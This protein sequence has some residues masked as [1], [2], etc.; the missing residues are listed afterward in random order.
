MALRGVLRFVLGVTV[1]AG[2]WAGDGPVALQTAD[3]SCPDD[4][5]NI[6]VDCGNGTVTDTRSGLTWLKNASC[7]KAFDTGAAK[8]TWHEAVETVAN[9]SDLPD[10]VGT[11]C[12]GLT[13]DECDCGLADGSSPGEWRLPTIAEWRAMVLG[14]PGACTDPIITNDAGNDCWDESCVSVGACSFLDVQAAEYWSSSTFVPQPD[15][16]YA[17]SLTASEP[18]PWGFYAKS[19]DNAVY[20]WPVRGGQ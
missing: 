1:S 7:W 20:V 19:L 8:L 5:G 16:V 2:A 9:L 4:S 6:Y 11:A 18:P 17:V 3:P 10:G 14:T 12:E 13:P 15:H